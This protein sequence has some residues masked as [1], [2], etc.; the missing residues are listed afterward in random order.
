L[1][2]GI[3]FLSTFAATSLG[4]EAEEIVIEKQTFLVSES[5][6]IDKG[7]F[8]NI[9]LEESESELLERGKPILPIISQTYTYPL[10]TIIKDIK[11]DYEIEQKELSKMIE[12]APSPMPLLNINGLLDN[13]SEPVYDIETYASEALYPSEPY[14]INKGIGQI[15]GVTH[16]ILN[17]KITPQYSPVN[18]IIYIPKEKINIQ[19]KYE[20]R[21][22]KTIEND[23]YELVIIT[24]EQFVPELQSLVKHKNNI[25]TPTMLKTVEE[26]YTEYPDGRDEAEK[27]KLF[28]YNM[29]ENYDIKYVLLAGGRKGQTNKWHI[30]SR[31]TL[32][33][34]GWESGYESDLYFGDVFK[35]DEQ[36]G[37]SFD[38]W[39][40][41][42]NGKIA[43]YKRFNP[44]KP[45]YYPEISVGRIP[46][47]YNFEIKPVV[48]K[49]IAYEQNTDESWFKKGIVISGDTFPPS[50]GGS[51]GWWEGE[52]ETAVTVDLLESKEFVM[53]K[54]WLSIPNVWT[55]PQDVINAISGGSGFVHFAGHG[56]PASW[57][58]HPPDDEDHVFI[59][60]LGLEDMPQL[61]NGNQNPII[62]VGGCHNAQFNTTMFNIIEG[63]L[64]Y[65]ISGYFFTRPLRFYYYEWVPR[66]FCSWL[67]MKKDGGAIGSMG[68]TGLGY[69]YVNEFA[70]SG[71]GG[72]IEPRFFDAYVNQTVEI[73]GFAHDQAIIDYINII[74]NIHN[75]NIDRKTIEEWV[76]IG[77]P[78]I[79]MG[80]NI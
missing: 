65:G 74:G 19:V 68:N 25:G 53:E 56:N 21:E 8:V 71:L 5:Q 50:R 17:I 32:N 39:D 73:L 14:E 40:S 33:D 27:I 63:I 37:Y 77:D 12:P 34:D 52:M 55:G 44:D 2:A 1:L 72:W 16:V 75:D 66:D 49:I 76:L 36:Q 43:E 57:G 31:R 54:L 58:N 30:P 70:L 48:D 3:L 18:N 28:L 22:I 9:D 24:I 10:G 29:K 61:S 35:Y 69:G 4:N 60:G 45:D 62:I 59:E 38:D 47:R 79:K 7:N 13:P 67:T 23:D 11:L 15:N 78:S 26:I 51:P 46:F 80:G 64:K 42:E 41:N 6:I 20:Q